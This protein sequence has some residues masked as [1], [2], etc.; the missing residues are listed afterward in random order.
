MRGGGRC[1]PRE[2]IAALEHGNQPAARV[3]I[4]D[5][6]HNERQIGEVLIGKREAPQRI[7]ETRVEACRNQ[8]QIRLEMVGSPP[9]AV[10]ENA[11]YFAVPRA[12]RK[13]AV[14]SA[15][16]TLALAAL[17]RVTGARIP[18]RLVRAEEEYRAVV[19]ESILRSV[20]VMDVPIRNQHALDSVLELGVAR[21]DRDIV[22][23]AEAHALVRT[24]MMPGR[25]HRTKSVRGCLLKNQ[26]DSVHHAA[27]S[28]QSD[29][30]RPWADGGIAGAQ[31]R[32]TGSD[33]T[34]DSLNVGP[35]VAQCDFVFGGRT[36]GY[37]Q[38]RFGQPG[39]VKGAR[40]RVVAFGTLRMP[41]TR[42]V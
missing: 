5:F 7:T 21:T 37:V 20:A 25:T 23:D 40:Q 4:G 32:R 35:C 41:G 6:E 33:V 13:W 27:S 34:L 8:H 38:E 3:L 28:V 29:F 10:L 14:H 15:A 18:G 11:Q 31:F 39:P 36:S 17:V 22:K 26:V 30:Q 42:V 12:R 19:V 16:L 9:Q 2:I 24:S 1:Q